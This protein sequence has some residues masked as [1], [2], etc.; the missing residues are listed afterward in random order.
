METIAYNHVKLYT[1][2]VVPMGLVHWSNAATNLMH[3]GLMLKAETS[4]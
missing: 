3:H 2:R 1:Y 4:V